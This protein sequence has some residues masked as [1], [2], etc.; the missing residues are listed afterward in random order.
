MQS[1]AAPHRARLCLG[2]ALWAVLGA[3]TALAAPTSTPEATTSAPEPSPADTHQL[4]ES[5]RRSVRAAT[6]WVARGVDSWF[7][8]QPFEDGGQVSNGYISLALLQRQG[9]P[10]E[11]G[12]AHV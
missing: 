12:R 1:A 11:I 2:I 5:A 9:E 6:E 10:L 7:G 4:A 8:S 3:P